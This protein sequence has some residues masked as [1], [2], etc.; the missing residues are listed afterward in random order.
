M[1]ALYMCE[2]CSH[3]SDSENEKCPV[4]GGKMIALDEP[5]KAAAKI[6]GT[7]DDIDLDP[8]TDLEADLLTNDEV[9]DGVVSLEALGEEED[10][11]TDD[12]YNNNE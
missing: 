3:E 7:D 9:S 8:S 4:C 12:Y 1:T 10:N 5:D 2:D 11:D 6:R